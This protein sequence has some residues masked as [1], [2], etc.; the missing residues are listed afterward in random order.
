[1]YLPTDIYSTQEFGGYEAYARKARTDVDI[2][3]KEQGDVYAQA[4]ST[5]T[6]QVLG[7]VREELNSVNTQLATVTQTVNH[8]VTIV[9]DLCTSYRT[10]VQA[11][12]T[13]QQGTESTVLA[14]LKVISD[15]QV[16][17]QKMLTKMNQQQ[18]QHQQILQQR[19]SIAE[20]G[21]IIDALDDIDD[22]D[23]DMMPG[24]L[25]DHQEATTVAG[26]SAGAAVS[27]QT[28]QTR[29]NK[30]MGLT[31][32]DVM[33]PIPRK[34]TVTDQF[35]EKWTV[36]VA[37]WLNNDLESFVKAKKKLWEAPALLQRYLKRHLA[38]KELRRFKVKL[39]DKRKD[40]S[41]VAKIL[42]KDRE[43]KEMSMSKHIDYL[44]AEN[45]TIIRRV[46]KP[47]VNN[48]NNNT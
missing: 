4:V 8:A 31:V 11:D 9:E 1:M 12:L 38:M 40:E 36:L 35:P 43:A 32:F 3:Q 30:E 13:R 28:A 47:K 16:H 37:E 21:G 22:D 17:L 39:G 26:D 25:P 2:L 20:T 23:F 19:Q 45:N 33:T 34:P 5:A 46:R 10:A 14:Q 29:R 6:A 15:Q 44:H 7:S 48:T 24:L 18:Q 42:D 41:A 27:Y